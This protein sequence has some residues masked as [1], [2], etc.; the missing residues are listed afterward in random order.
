MSWCSTRCAVSH[1]SRPCQAERVCTRSRTRPRSSVRQ[2]AT[3]RWPACCSRSEA[4]SASSSKRG[5]GSSGKSDGG[6]AGSAVL[7][8]PCAE[9]RQVRRKRRGRDLLDALAE[10]VLEVHFERRDLFLEAREELEFLA[11]RLRSAVV[12]DELD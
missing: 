5:C 2:I 12:R 8:V 9:T 11:H 1:S 4:C 6:A 7:L 3:S 10:L